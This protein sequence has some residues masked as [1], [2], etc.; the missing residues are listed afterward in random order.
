[1]NSGKIVGVLAALSLAATAR[2]VVP[3]VG[4]V[5]M[6]QAENRDVT[7]SYTLSAPGVVTLDIVTNSPSGWISIGSSNVLNVTGDVWTRVGAGAH[8]ISWKPARVWNGNSVKLEQGG[9]KAVV[10][11]WALDDPPD[12]MVVDVRAGDA[13][14]AVRFYPS[15]A[16]L[17]GG[18]LANED[19]RLSKIVMRRIDAVNVPWTMGSNFEPG[20]AA[21]S[22]AAHTVTLAHNYYIGVFELTQGQF[23]EI[24]GID[25]MSGY[26]NREHARL[27]PLNTVSYNK[28]RCAPCTK[29][30]ADAYIDGGWPRSPHE[31]SFLGLLRARTGVA[32][33]LPTEAEWEFACRAGTCE[34]QWNNGSVKSDATLPGEWLNGKASSEAA[35]LPCGSYEPN[36]WGLYDMHGNIYELCHDWHQNDITALGGA[37]NVDPANP[38]NMLDGTPGSAR[39][40]RGGACHCA[41]NACSASIRNVSYNPAASDSK[42]GYRL[43]CPVGIDD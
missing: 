26:R 3:E 20:R 9:V 35:P 5:S 34:G 30:G 25:D 22:E 12:Y 28:M 23:V 39:V 36:R 40:R 16:F 10:T 31:G 1:M 7:I 38:L 27:L 18:L 8:E 15:A 6:T 24:T 42:W 21:A 29:N 43:V 4:D 17:P 14:D 37:A 11:A 41:A 33:D 19:Y 2:A 13:R 32:F